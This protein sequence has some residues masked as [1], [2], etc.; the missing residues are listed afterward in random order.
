VLLRA[1]LVIVFAVLAVVPPTAGAQEAVRRV[2]LDEALTLFAS[3]SL[4][5]RISRADAA[6]LVVTA[7]QAGAYPNP[8][9]TAST[10]RLGNGAA[11]AY[12]ESY[13]NLSQRFDWPWLASARAGAVRSRAAAGASRVSADSVRLTFD[14][15][16]AFVDAAT[17]EV[18]HA[19]LA[20]ATDLVRLGERQAGQRAAAGDISRYELRRLRVERF[21]YETALSAAT[22]ALRASR[23]RL[24][25]LVLPDSTIELAPAAVRPGLPPPV[26]LSGALETARAR[27]PL[28]AEVRS[29]ATAAAGEWRAANADRLP[30]P[31]LVAGYKTQSDGAAGIY[32]GAGLALPLFDRRGAA[33]A[34]AAAR[35]DA[36]S[37]RAA[38]VARQIEMD[39]RRAHE[40]FEAARAQARL[41]GDSAAAETEALLPIARLSYEEGE[42]TLLELLDAVDAYRAGR[43][44]VAET[45]A[46]LW[47]SYFDLERAVG[48][49]LT[50]LAAW[51]AR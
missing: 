10:E 47:T 18:V 15:R 48:H 45:L 44:A 51:E 4:E 7:R 35:V 11:G 39:V 36:A 6:D 26:P 2:T 42:M 33:A 14:V 29:L 21:R 12:R 49:S 32:L 28:R 37:A 24:A 22:L 16:R 43:V 5:L 34:A 27:H 1:A 40:A 20:E 50:G 46:S 30:S 31:T 17:A 13:L 38:L 25:G 41:L 23:R 8:V 3:H 19:T 9:V